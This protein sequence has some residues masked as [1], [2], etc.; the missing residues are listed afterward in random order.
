ME[1][2]NVRFGR[3]LKELRK[4]NKLTQEGLSEASGLDYKYIQRLEGK[5]PSSPT[6]NSVEKIA[7]AFKIKPSK[8]LE[9]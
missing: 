1:N 4:E 3:R 8:L 2:I 6:L 7:N 5:R 9:F